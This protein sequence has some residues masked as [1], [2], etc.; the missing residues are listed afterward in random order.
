MATNDWRPKRGDHVRN[1]GT[2]EEATAMKFEGN[3]VR[4]HYDLIADPQSPD[5]PKADFMTPIHRMPQ[6]PPEWFRLDE[7]E[8][9]E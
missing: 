5:A 1:R 4:V 6:R 9:V 3:R 7:L 2:G 8:P